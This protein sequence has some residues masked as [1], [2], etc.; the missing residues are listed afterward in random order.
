M[1]VIAIAAAVGKQ[2]PTVVGG[3]HVQNLNL[4]LREACQRRLCWYFLK[5]VHDSI[6]RWRIIDRHGRFTRFGDTACMEFR[7]GEPRYPAQKM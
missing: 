1:D 3:K 7:D 2:I 4:N 5:K 6:A